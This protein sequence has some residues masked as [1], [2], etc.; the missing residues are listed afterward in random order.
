[1]SRIDADHRYL[2]PAHRTGSR[3]AAMGDAGQ[4]GL[5]PYAELAPDY[6]FDQRIAW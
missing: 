5:D 1:V 4:G 6:E 3:P 2:T